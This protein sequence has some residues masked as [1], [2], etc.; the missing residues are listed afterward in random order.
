MSVREDQDHKAIA[1][2]MFINHAAHANADV[3]AA[4]LRGATIYPTKN[5]RDYT[6]ESLLPVAPVDAVS[7]MRVLRHLEVIAKRQAPRIA[8]KAKGKIP[9]LEFSGH[10]CRASRR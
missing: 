7:L 5:R 4:P 3:S 6:F 8:F 2:E 9:A 1:G 10:C